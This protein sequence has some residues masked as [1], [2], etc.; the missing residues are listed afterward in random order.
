LLQTSLLGVFVDELDLGAGVEGVMAETTGRP[1]CHPATMLKIYVYGYVHQIQSSRRLERETA[2]IR[3]A[4]GGR[5][6]ATELHVM[7]S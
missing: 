6:H 7:A 1:A 4:R 5:K 3:D 2:R